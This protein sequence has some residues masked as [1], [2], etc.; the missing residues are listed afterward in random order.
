MAPLL[1]TL[2]GVAAVALLMA[3]NAARTRCRLV[4]H[5][6]S[7]PWT[8]EGRRVHRCDRCYKVVDY[9]Y[10]PPVPFGGP[11]DQLSIDGEP[12]LI[13]VTV[14]PAPPKP[15]ELAPEPEELE[16]EDARAVERA[17]VAASVRQQWGRGTDSAG[18]N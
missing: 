14:G 13:K 6:W 9:V 15:E 3:A 18:V 2:A 1:L 16:A 8:D 10:V 5:D 12:G 7:R 4:G 11:L 17:R